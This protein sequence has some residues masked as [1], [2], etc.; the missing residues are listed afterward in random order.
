MLSTFSDPIIDLLQP[1]STV[2][3]ILGSFQI[4]CNRSER[5]ESVCEMLEKQLENQPFEYPAQV[6]HI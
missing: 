6:K 1:P 3:E 2:D 4:L 5:F